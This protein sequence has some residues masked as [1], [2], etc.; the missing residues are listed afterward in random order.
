[1]T[2]ISLKRRTALAAALLAGVFGIPSA[3]AAPVVSFITPTNA[4]VLSIPVVISLNAAAS[5]SGGTVTNVAFYHGTNKLANVSAAPYNYIWR[6]VPVGSYAL[7]AVATDAGGMATTSSVVNI[8]VT[9]CG[10]KTIFVIPLENHDWV[11]A[12]PTCSPDQISNNPAALYVNSLVKPGNSNA[13]QVSFATKYYSVSD[14]N[15]GEHPSE[16]NYVWSEAGTDFG[17]RTDNDPSA[18]SGNLFT[19]M[20]LSGQLTAAGY[21]WKSYQEDL[22]YT[23][24]ATVSVNSTLTGGATNIYNGSTE[25]AYAVKHNPMEFFTDTTNKNVYPLTTFWTDLTNNAV[26]RYNW[27][28]PNLFNEMHSGLTSYTYHGVQYTGD[29]AAVAE[30]DNCLSIIVPKIMASTA[31]QDHGVIIIWTDETESTDTTTTTL[32]YF[33]ISPL[34]KGNAYASTVVYCHASDLKMMDEIFGLAYQTN[35]IPPSEVDAQGTGLNYVNGSSAVINDLSDFF[36]TPCGPPAITRSF[37]NLTL[38][39]GTNCSAAMIDV[40]GANYILASESCSS[41]ALTITQTPAAQTPLAAGTSNQVVIAVA[42]GAGNTALSTNWI[43]VADVTPPVIV[44]QPASLTNDAGTSASFSVGAT[45]C[46]PLYYQWY[47]GTNLLAG[48]TNSTLSITS[49]GPANVGYYSVVVTSGGG[50]TN[51]SVAALTVIYQSPNIVGGQLMLG[52]GGFQL[53]FSGPPGQTYKVLASGDLSLPTP[54][55]RIAGTGTFG[56]GNVIFTDSSATNY[57][58]QFYIIQSP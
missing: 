16:P 6:S 2:K 11:Q 13:A 34:A 54:A 42:D 14:G 32:P 57:S 55:W 51:S 41:S 47:L 46:T 33:I 4:A 8:T 48:Q 12:C 24:S 40:T 44:S 19:A 7:T 37:T 38:N 22:Q 58:S 9:L 1:M 52:P 28:T 30:G 49:V 21:V 31:Y 23:T 5:E 53:T 25:I 43:V 15:G 26:G 39:A 20:H 50:S 17:I 10:I 3:Q 56:S 45:A 29:Q 27:I 36:Q 35:V 18:A